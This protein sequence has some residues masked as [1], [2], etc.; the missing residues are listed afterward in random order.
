VTKTKSF[1][2]Q[3]KE[4]LDPEVLKKYLKRSAVAGTVI[5]TVVYVLLVINLIALGLW[6][7]VAIPLGIWAWATH[8][9]RSWTIYTKVTKPEQKWEQNVTFNVTSDLTAEQIAEAAR[10]AASTE[11]YYGLTKQP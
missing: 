8:V 7:V 3:V 6:P 10:K 1:L 4:P 9:A 11:V 2:E 5:W